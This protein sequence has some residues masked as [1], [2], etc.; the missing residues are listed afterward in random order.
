[1]KRFA[2]GTDIGGSH[3]SCAVIDFEKRSI[4]RGSHV[5]QDVDNQAPAVEILARWALA[6]GKSIAQTQLQHLAGIGFAMPGPFDYA[7]GVALFTRDVA[8]YQNLHGLDISEHLKKSLALPADFELRYSNDATAF[9]VG[10]AWW[11][12]ASAARRFLSLTLGTGLGSAFL[13]AGIPVVEREDVPAMGCLWHLPFGDDIADASFSTRWFVKRYAQ[14]SG[15]LLADVKQVADRAADDSLARDVF[16]EFGANLGNFLG[17]W[18]S[19]FAADMLVIGG[20]VA[21]AYPLF[22]TALEESLRRQ[23]L[24]T[25]IRL[26]DLKEDAALI[27]SARLFQDDFWNQVKPLLPKMGTSS[28]K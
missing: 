21:A 4:A 5:T 20:N 3:I 6:L 13:D 27:G 28:T 9:G 23:R 19:R 14:K 7:R 17:P 1:M 10:E 12:K 24:A 25:A 22:G 18:L 2:I 15:T 11:G 26:S 16:A 8:K